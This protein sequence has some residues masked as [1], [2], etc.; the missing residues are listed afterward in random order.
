MLA[1]R[2]GDP[3]LSLWERCKKELISAPSPDSETNEADAQQC[4][5]VPGARPVGHNAGN[6]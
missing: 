4:W 3:T 1:N 5:W 6:D 2:R